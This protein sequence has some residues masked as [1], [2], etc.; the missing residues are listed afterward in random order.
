MKRSGEFIGLREN[1][2]ANTVRKENMEG[3]ILPMKMDRNLKEAI[4]EVLRCAD[5]SKKTKEEIVRTI[6]LLPRIIVSD[7]HPKPTQ[8]I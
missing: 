6:M 5:I 4:I 1:L 8:P 2:R 3:K 7:S